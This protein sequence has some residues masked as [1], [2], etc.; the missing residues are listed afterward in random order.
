MVNPF[1]ASRGHAFPPPR[2]D[3]EAPL[4]V[5]PG[6]AAV[7]DRPLLGAVEAFVGEAR[8]H[9]DVSLVVVRRAG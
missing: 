4:A 8:W 2:G 5:E 1:H 9:D 6:L 3:E 7:D